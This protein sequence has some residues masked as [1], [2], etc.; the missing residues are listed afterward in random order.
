MSYW[1]NVDFPTESYKL[2]RKDCRHCTPTETPLKGFKELKKDGG[3]LEFSSKKEARVYWKLQHS[4]L[5]WDPCR[6]CF[7]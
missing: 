3:W 6:I 4:N 5:K 7:P 1:V 2:H